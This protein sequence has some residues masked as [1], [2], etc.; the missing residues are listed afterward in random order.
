VV[1]D[2]DHFFVGKRDEVGELVGEELARTLPVPS[3]LP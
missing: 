3:H 1:R 2:V